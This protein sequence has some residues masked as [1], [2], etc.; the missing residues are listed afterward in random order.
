[1]LHNSAKIIVMNANWAII[2]SGLGLVLLELILG[3]ATGFDLLLVG[4]ALTMGGLTGVAFSSE[5][6]GVIT[7]TVFILIYFFLGRKFIK[8]KLSVLSTKTNIDGL[9]G[10]TGTVI[11]SEQIK[12][13]TEIW[14][15]KSTDLL[16]PGDKAKV[17]S[18]EGNTLEVVLLK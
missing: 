7:S 15:C 11:K 1:M 16:N 14:R 18:V 10:K 13:D 17:I 2:F 12:V 6:V 5:Q 8:K 3:A 9:I 4:L